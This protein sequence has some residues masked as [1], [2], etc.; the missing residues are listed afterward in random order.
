[1]Q[2]D[3]VIDQG[4]RTGIVRR[5]GRIIVVMAA[6][7]ACALVFGFMLFATSV[8]RE[9][10]QVPAAGVAHADGIVVL[11]GA[12]AR[13]SAG[14][15]L[16]K[17]GHGKRLLISGVNRITTKHDIER[18]SGL[19]HKSFTC[20]VDLGYEALDTVGNADE[21]RSWAN[22]NGY[23]KL[24]IVTSSYHM[25]RALAELAL[26]MPEAEFVPHTV[27]PKDFPE[28]GWWLNVRT[29]RYLLS[30]YL[31]YLPAAARL[32]TQRV[33]GWGQSHSVA[34]DPRNL[35]HPDRRDG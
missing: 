25:P 20:C 6:C 26:T 15:E 30:E 11:T 1:M 16:L 4:A 32:A 10:P 8:M 12:A 17:E 35:Q 14:A 2:A 34:L 24:I 28:S 5:I 3:Q 18:L 31:K 23:R 21:T 27:T 7:A 19:D 22:A 9:Q 33:M 13:I 29:T